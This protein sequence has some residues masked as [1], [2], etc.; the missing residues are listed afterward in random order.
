MLDVSAISRLALTLSFKVAL[1][2]GCWL[3]IS[4]LDLSICNFNNILC[5]ASS[6]IQVACFLYFSLQLH[7]KQKQRQDS[8]MMEMGSRARIKVVPAIAVIPLRASQ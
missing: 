6:K 7:G 8:I 4:A 2:C 5:T 1:F 3:M